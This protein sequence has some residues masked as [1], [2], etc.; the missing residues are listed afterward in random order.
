MANI[1]SDSDLDK[2]SLHQDET[3]KAPVNFIL[4]R[5][6]GVYGISCLKIDNFDS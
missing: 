5:A 1:Y 6:S 3:I 2:R 4:H